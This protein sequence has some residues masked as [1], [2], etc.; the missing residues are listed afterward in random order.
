MR[1]PL[2][3]ERRR[4]ANHAGPWAQLPSGDLAA[5]RP[6]SLFPPS[7][8]RHHRARARLPR[9]G[10]HGQGAFQCRQRQG[11]FQRRSPNVGDLESDFRKITVD[12]RLRAV[13]N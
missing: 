7:P 10:S 2:Y 11:V 12:P 4:T 3:H 5:T 8:R 9:V 13:L 1:G 6:G